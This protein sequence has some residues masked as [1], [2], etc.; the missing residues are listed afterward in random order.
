MCTLFSSI[1]LYKEI[2]IHKKQCPG[3]GSKHDYGTNMY[4]KEKACSRYRYDRGAY[5]ESKAVF[6]REITALA[7]EKLQ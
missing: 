6:I 4:M 1:F 7:K 5:T 2:K 3:C